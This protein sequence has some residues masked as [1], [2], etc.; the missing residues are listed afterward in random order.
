MCVI[1]NWTRSIVVLHLPTAETLALLPPGCPQPVAAR[2]PIGTDPPVTVCAARCL[3]EMIPMCGQTCK[4]PTQGSSN[5]P[6]VHTRSHPLCRHM[7]S[8]V[9][10]VLRLVGTVWWSCARAARA[11]IRSAFICSA[12]SDTNL[13][14]NVQE[15]LESHVARN[16]EPDIYTRSPPLSRPSC[17]SCSSWLVE[18]LPFG[19][20][21]G[22]TGAAVRRVYRGSAFPPAAVQSVHRSAAG[23]VPTSPRFSSKSASFWGSTGICRSRNAS[24]RLMKWSRSAGSNWATA[25]AS[26]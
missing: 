19:S 12:W 17:S 18:L 7:C 9:C 16:S 4:K 2:H 24:T 5:A 22:M 20:Q 14:S 23:Q 6:D 3:R 8:C 15:N 11:A 10:C 13:P 1:V 26:S 25:S 21:I